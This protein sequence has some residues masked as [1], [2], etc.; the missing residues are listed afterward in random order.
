MTLLSIF[1]PKFREASKPSATVNDP[2]DGGF[3]TKYWFWGAAGKIASAL[4]KK[5]PAHKTAADKILGR[6]LEKAKGVKPVKAA[7]AAKIELPKTG[8]KKHAKAH[9]ADSA[10]TNPVIT[11]G[12]KKETAIQFTTH[13]FREAAAVKQGVPSVFDVVLIEEGLGNFGDAFYYT[14]EAIESAAALFEGEKCFCDHP[15]Q[16]EEED[17]PE[18]T[19]RDIL[20][21]F[22]NCEAEPGDGGRT[23]L[24]ASLD[25]LNVPKTEL[26]RAQM[27]RAVQN[28]EKF[29]KEFVGLSI[30]AGGDSE[31][32]TIEAVMASAP[33]GAKPKLQE[34][35]DKGIETVRVVSRITSVVSCDLVTKAGAGGK[36]LTIIEGEK[37]DVKK[38]GK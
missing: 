15:K 18:R 34:A 7:K 27:V 9:Q 17:R 21:H 37:T 32:Q 30:N 28:R 5:Q 2:I 19:T 14:K 4:D 6:H 12:K 23:V 20:G 1:Y 22:E 26:Q 29:N 3:K 25:V 16:S 8:E 24:S 13:S 10:S 38:E 35:M 33:D 11:T 36:I 31:E